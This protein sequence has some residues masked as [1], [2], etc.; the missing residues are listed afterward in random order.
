MN[1]MSVA[2]EAARAGADVLADYFRQGVTMRTK[3][4]SADLVSDADVNAE[5]AVAEVILRHCP[6]HAILGE[7]ENTGDV[8]AQ[9]LWVVDPLDGT[10]NFAHGIPHF[11]TSVAYYKNGKATVGVVLNPITGDLWQA[12]VGEGAT[13]NGE[14][15]SVSDEKRLS[16]SLVGTGF[17]YDRGA[18]MQHTLQSIER[19]FGQQIHGIRRFG[20]ASLDLAAVA[21]GR[22]G[23]YFEYQLHPWDFAAGRLL[24]EEA[25]GKVT[26]C[27][28]K[29][30]PL[31]STT[32]LATNGHLHE[33]TLEQVRRE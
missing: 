28:G 1:Q 2:I 13:L 32:I 14:A 19:L 26:N 18:M 29:E 12:A 21:T 15:I 25:G 30:L 7:E 3:S 16:D 8:S 33:A 20:T 22:V 9:H 17:Y 31:A 10:T 4:S 27:A 6:D 24:V 5:R 23:A 11:A